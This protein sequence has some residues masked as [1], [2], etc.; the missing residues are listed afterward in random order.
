MVFDGY[1]W[2]P[3]DSVEAMITQG[4]IDAQG[5]AYGLNDSA[6]DSS[7]GLTSAPAP[8]P[9]PAPTPTPVQKKGKVLVPKAA[10]I[11]LDGQLM[12]ARAIAE[13][14]AKRGWEGTLML[15]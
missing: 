15:P 1:S 5:P 11:P 6:L 8:A 7:T 9:L 12:A 2:Y 14:K 13:L 3:K 10:R 4:K